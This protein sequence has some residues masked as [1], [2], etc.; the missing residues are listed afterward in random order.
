MEVDG[1]RIGHCL[2][3]GKEK[4]RK[5]EQ[6]LYSFFVRLPKYGNARFPEMIDLSS[7]DG[8]PDHTADMPGGPALTRPP[9]DDRRNMSFAR[10]NSSTD[11]TLRDK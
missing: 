2:R 1:E 11:H 6:S 7:S 9:S 8:T 10:H 4:E 3:G 5:E